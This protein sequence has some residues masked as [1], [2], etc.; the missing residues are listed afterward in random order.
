MWRQTSRNV[1]ITWLSKDHVSLLLE[2][3]VTWSGV[4]VVL[5]VMCMLMWPWPDPR[6][7]SRGDDRQ[8]PSTTFDCKH[9]HN[10][11]MALFRG[12][13]GWAGA[14]RNLLL[15]FMVQ[16]QIT[17]AL[18]T[19][20]PAGRY[21]IRTNQRP[22]SIIP[23]FFLYLMPFLNFLPQPSHLGQTPNMLA[24]IPSGVVYCKLNMV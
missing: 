23:P 20:H 14:R 8:P 5:Y 15:D 9:T 22:T 12:L 18:H 21:S 17:E 3:R 1:D 6:S 2:V 11:F 19:D 10:C 7:R 13:P 24:C 4:L 16:G